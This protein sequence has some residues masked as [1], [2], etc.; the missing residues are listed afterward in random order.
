MINMTHRFYFFI[1]MNGPAV[2]N[3]TYEN[4]TRLEA[5]NM[6]YEYC[7]RAGYFFDDYD[8]VMFNQCLTGFIF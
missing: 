1:D 2:E 4:M 3:R 5:F 7:E 6:A 8:D